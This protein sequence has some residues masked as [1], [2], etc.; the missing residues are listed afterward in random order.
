MEGRRFGF[1]LAAGLLFALA[2][3]SG[4]GG[5]GASYSWIGS[6]SPAHQGASPATTTTYAAATTTATAVMSSTTGPPY[7]DVNGNTNGTSNVPQGGGSVT[8]TTTSGTSTVP[9]KDI[10]AMAAVLTPLSGASR[11]NSIAQQPALSN[12]FLLIPVFAAFLVG[13]LVYRVSNG[14]NRES[15]ESA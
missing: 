15:E 10:Q 5:F 14:S 4:A 6:L 11:V 12:A 8:T 7:Y 3:V 2:V 9:Q 13:A 1:G